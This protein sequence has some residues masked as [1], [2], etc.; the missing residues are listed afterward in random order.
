MTLYIN[1]DCF[2][3][4]NS[5][6]YVMENRGYM[7]QIDL[8]LPI[9]LPLQ[10]F[11]H[12]QA[13]LHL[14]EESFL[15]FIAFIHVLSQQGLQQTVRFTLQSPLHR[16]L[17]QNKPQVFLDKTAKAVIMDCFPDEMTDIQY[18]L[19]KTR[20]KNWINPPGESRWHFLQRVFNTEKIFLT[21][22]NGTWYIKEKSPPIFRVNYKNDDK[23]NI[24]KAPATPFP[25]IALPLLQTARVNGIHLDKKSCYRLRWAF[26]PVGS[27]I[28]PPIPSIQTHL[29]YQSPLQRHQVVLTSQLGSTFLSPHIVTT[30]SDLKEERPL[31]WETP[32]NHY[33]TWDETSEQTTKI[34][35][36]QSRQVYQQN[37]HNNASMLF[38]S[39]D[40]QIVQRSQQAIQSMSEK[41]VLFV[42]SHK[43]Y[44]QARHSIKVNTENNFR[45]QT[46]MGLLSNAVSH[47]FKSS[48]T[49]LSCKTLLAQS[50]QQITQRTQTQQVQ[51]KTMI[52]HAN[53]I[54]IS[55]TTQCQLSVGSSCITLHKDGLVEFS[56]LS[57]CAQG[58]SISGYVTESSF[59]PSPTKKGL[60]C[61][62]HRTLPTFPFHLE[63]HIIDAHWMPRLAN[64]QQTVNAVFTLHGSLSHENGTITFKHA[65][66]HIGEKHF[67][68]D[69]LSGKVSV[70]VSLNSL[71]IDDS[72]RNRFVQTKSLATLKQMPGIQF[73]VSMNTLKQTHASDQL[74]LQYRIQ[75]R[76]DLGTNAALPQGTVYYDEKQ[77]TLEPPISILPARTGR[78][79]K[80]SIG[81]SEFSRQKLFLLDHKA[82]NPWPKV[83]VDIGKRPHA[84]PKISLKTLAPAMLVNAHPK[85]LR[86][87]TTEERRLLEVLTKKHQSS[88]TI[89]IHGYNI[90]LG[91]YSKVIHDVDLENDRAVI[92]FSDIPSTL[93][94]DAYQLKERFKSLKKD[95]AWEPGF[96]TL[97]GAGAHQWLL[98]MEYHLNAA[99]GNTRTDY[100]NYQRIIGFSWSGDVQS[101]NYMQ[102]VSQAKPAAKKLV[103]L[104]EQ[105]RE[106]GV[107][108]I[109]LIAHSL[110]NCVALQAMNQLG[111]QQRA[112]LDEVFLWQAAVPNDV[113]SF[114]NGRAKNDP[115]N[116]PYAINAAK[117]ITVLYSKNDNILGPIPK[118]KPS[119]T[120]Q[121][122]ID[123]EKDL[124]EFILATLLTELELGSA[125][126]TAMWLGIPASHLLNPFM[127]ASLYESWI[128]Q[129]PRDQHGCAF[130]KSF[131]EQIKQ[132]DKQS[133]TRWKELATQ[134]AEA[135]KKISH[136]LK[137]AH[138]YK[139]YI[140]SE[141]IRLAAN[142]PHL[143]EFLGNLL[144]TTLLFKAVPQLDLFKRLI[145]LIETIFMSTTYQPKPAL[146]YSGIDTSSAQTA[147]YLAT[148]KISQID[149][150]NWLYAHSAM[151]N[152]STAVQTHSFVNIL[153]KTLGKKGW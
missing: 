70:P 98:S 140:G 77:H 1:Q 44:Q 19:S 135:E 41:N 9:H 72:D 86:P 17:T 50:G 22:Q 57:L 95:K 147:H 113:L 124:D 7:F 11:F 35:T 67:T 61:N 133:N 126:E 60:H 34:K 28:S 78:Q 55:A 82:Q 121:A 128:T 47:R 74:N 10:G 33:L 138:R 107:K 15:G 71:S 68:F 117:H 108:H 106:I 110:G 89:F 134:L 29:L 136:R 97:N 27:E 130:P 64:S 26:N 49:K 103:Q 25:K 111:K 4:K 141:C 45:I 115:W 146:G 3:V 120:L 43:S 104:I 112:A 149:Q 127:Q 51:T 85:K 114:N 21:F 142:H 23:T 54:E 119:K 94:L 143:A 102:A 2:R 76:C 96:D 93:Y 109:H 101:A 40:G 52:T 8:V 73:F 53:S 39:T 122:K 83:S 30:L 87:L 150:S 145:T 118:N 81:V 48:L 105:L 131:N 36:I 92:N 6:G 148:G 79:W 18:S 80:A 91:E 99:A 139:A 56:T 88:I 32:K 42:T 123:R 13:S 38:R 116:L 151:L 152:P 65:H 14:K 75:L 137:A 100:N 20:K 5:H 12:K 46:N 31:H 16:L 84:E 69:E 24:E 59:T 90:P 129:H 58:I 37:N 125:Y 63:K 62:P 153:I 144:P 132:M 66:K